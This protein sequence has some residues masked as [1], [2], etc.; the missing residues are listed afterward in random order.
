M[1]LSSILLG[2]KNST[3]LNAKSIIVS[4]VERPFTK[5]NH[6]RN[7]E[8]AEILI[9]LN[10]NF[11]NSFRVRNLSSVPSA[12]FGLKDRLVATI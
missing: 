1:H 7:I 8:I 3:V 2:I 6:A 10:S 5:V 12:S 4:A 9:R 11:K